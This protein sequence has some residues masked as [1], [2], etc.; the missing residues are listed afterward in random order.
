[1]LIYDTRMSNKDTTIWLTLGSFNLSFATCQL[2]SLIPQNIFALKYL[3]L[4]IL[5]STSQRIHK[6]IS[7]LVNVPV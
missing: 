6:I 4:K 5:E 3:P 7:N 1:M 2:L